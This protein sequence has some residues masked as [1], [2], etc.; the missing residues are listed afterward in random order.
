MSAKPLRTA[1]PRSV[2]SFGEGDLWI[3]QCQLEVYLELHQHRV[4][5]AFHFSP[6][7]ERLWLLH[8]RGL[9]R[10]SS[11]RRQCPAESA[12]PI[13]QSGAEECPSVSLPHISPHHDS[14]VLLACLLAITAYYIHST[15]HHH[16]S[17]ADITKKQSQRPTTLLQHQTRRIRSRHL[18]PRSRPLLPL[19][20]EHQTSLRLHHRLLPLRQPPKR[21]RLRSRRLGRHHPFRLRPATPKHLH[22][23]H[24][25]HR[26]GRQEEEKDF[27][28]KRT[29]SGSR[30]KGL[31]RGN[32]TRNF[33]PARPK[34]Q[35]S[36]HGCLG[37]NGREALCDFDTTLECATVGRTVDMD[38][39][40]DVWTMARATGRDFG[41]V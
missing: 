21:T 30:R 7:A 22:P 33:A 15:N 28:Q 16:P 38:E 6:R 35:I 5:H 37:Q 4:H 24:H 36:N 25:H 12:E 34:T 17:P 13:G 19:Q 23:P 3:V 10:R 41:G 1:S 11:H 2:T 40:P 26:K 8:I 14:Y 32:F 29:R 27:L 39:F 18:R 31:S 20:L 9:C